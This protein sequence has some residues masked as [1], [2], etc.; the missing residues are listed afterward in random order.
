MPEF[1]PPSEEWGLAFALHPRECLSL[2]VMCAFRWTLLYGLDI[3][4]PER[5]ANPP[6]GLLGF[7]GEETL[8][9]L[10]RSLNQMWK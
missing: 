9:C 4:D 1:T 8:S 5:S 2:F 10:N 3:L 6:T 7:S